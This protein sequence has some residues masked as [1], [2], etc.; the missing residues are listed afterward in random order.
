M[1]ALNSHEGE[2]RVPY[3]LNYHIPVGFIIT[4]I[5]L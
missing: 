2:S 4:N 1:Y 3:K 5:V